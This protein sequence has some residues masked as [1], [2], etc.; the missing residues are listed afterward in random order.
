[1]AGQADPALQPVTREIP[2]NGDRHGFPAHRFYEYGHFGTW[3]LFSEIVVFGLLPA[4][5]LTHASW[6]AK[7]PLMLTAAAAACAGITLNRFVLTIQTMALPTL[8][9]DR[10]LTYMPSWQEVA[11]F[12]AVVAYGV[13]VYSISFRYFNLFPQER[14]LARI[15]PVN[16]SQEA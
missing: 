13:L 16:S 1:M 15:R 14:E 5:V 6:R 10:L 11:A 7:R 8:P 3:I 2:G 9:F 12:G 4:L